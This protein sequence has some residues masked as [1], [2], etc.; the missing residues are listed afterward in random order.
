MEKGYAL[1][2]GT[3]KCLRVESQT[4]SWREAEAACEAEGGHLAFVEDVATWQAVRAFLEGK[5]AL[6][7]GLI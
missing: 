4:K 1:V 7:Q 3:Q 6:M 5:F 2:P